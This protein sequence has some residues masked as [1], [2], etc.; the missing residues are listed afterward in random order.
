MS[1]KNQD[2]FFF[3]KKIENKKYI[4][5]LLTKKVW[6]NLIFF[7]HNETT[8]WASRIKFQTLHNACITAIIFNFLFIDVF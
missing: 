8:F 5:F 3:F 4:V 2:S 1:I 7:L 6:K